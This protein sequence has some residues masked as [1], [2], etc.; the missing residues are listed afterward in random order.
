M[1]NYSVKNKLRLIE[2]YQRYFYNKASL[3]FLTGNNFN[4]VKIIK[5]NT[6]FLLHKNLKIN[7]EKY[8][9][10]YLNIYVKKL[11]LLEN[12]IILL[13][14]KKSIVKLNEFSFYKNENFNKDKENR[15]LFNE[16]LLDILKCSMLLNNRIYC[17][18]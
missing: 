15:P 14:N 9:T 12:M 16:I 13:K 4:L 3:F 6:S 1:C 8:L 18:F 10:R 11:E 17:I 5:I 2:E 7:A